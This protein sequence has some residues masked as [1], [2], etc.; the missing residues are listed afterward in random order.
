M[1]GMVTAKEMVC[2]SE[3]ILFLFF[4]LSAKKKHT[5]LCV[6]RAFAVK[7]RIVMRIN[8]IY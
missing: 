5:F 1:A 4:G 2:F 6:L 7:I 3:G 8:S